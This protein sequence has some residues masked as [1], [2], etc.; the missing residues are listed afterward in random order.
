MSSL[1]MEV[2]RVPVEKLVPAEKNVRMHPETQIKEYARSLEKNG[3]LRPVVIDE[4]YNV[5][6]GNGMLL[7]AKRLGWLELDA[8]VKPNLSEH[9]KMKLMVS[10]NKIF[11]LGTE[12]LAVLDAFLAELA[13][14]GDIP[15]F[16]DEFLQ[17]MFLDE[18]DVDE[19]VN[20]FGILSPT[21][22]KSMQSVAERREAA[23]KAPVTVSA[24]APSIEQSNTAMEQYGQATQT[25]TQPA[26]ERQAVVPNGSVNGSP[27]PLDATCAN[28][29]QTDQPQRAGNYIVCPHCGEKIWL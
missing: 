29:A 10:D 13:E 24:Q 20:N 4:H 25:A 27:E 14:E 18:D 12:N 16:D 7:A 28:N 17:M 1:K 15:G 5:W 2:V 22:L 23:E 19:Q 11:S 9:D 26:E 3:Q 8:I 21:E 6:I